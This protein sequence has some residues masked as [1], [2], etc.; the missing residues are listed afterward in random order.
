MSILAPHNL[1]LLRGLRMP[2]SPAVRRPC[3]DMAKFFATRPPPET[4]NGAAFAEARLAASSSGASAEARIAFGRA[5]ALVAEWV[6]AGSPLDLAALNAAVEGRAPAFRRTP[7]TLDGFACPSPDAIPQLLA[8]MAAA[9]VARSEDVHPIAGAGLLYQWLISVHPFEDGNG[10]TARL[11]V[12]HHL[13]LAGLPPACIR[14]TVADFVAIRP[15]DPPRTRER[16]D[17]ASFVVLRGLEE[18]ARLL[19]P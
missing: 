4:V 3:F 5:N 1:A 12:D 6:S 7:T 8:P 17:H 15:W 14:P 10:R 19:W 2:V 16:T 9:V 13:G 18:T 11:A